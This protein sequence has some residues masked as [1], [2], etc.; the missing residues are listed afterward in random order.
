MCRLNIEAIIMST[1]VTVFNMLIGR[2][3]TYIF[4]Y[5]IVDTIL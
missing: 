3:N 5:I 2:L 1:I 4:K